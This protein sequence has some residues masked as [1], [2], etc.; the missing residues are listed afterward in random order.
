MTRSSRFRSARAAPGLVVR[1]QN[2]AAKAV[3]VD[4]VVVHASTH[5][6]GW[7]GPV[8][9]NGSWRRASSRATPATA[10]R[11]GDT[12]IPNSDPLEAASLSSTNRISDGI[13]TT[14]AY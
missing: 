9:R 8:N 10:R 1:G 11:D 7:G 12:P 3:I 5:D 13:R 6:G 4:G 2:G 14:L